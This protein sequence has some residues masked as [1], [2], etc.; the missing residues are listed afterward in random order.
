MLQKTGAIVLHTLKYGESKLVVDM[1]T[2]QHGR[3]TFM[4]PLS[5]SPRS[6]M[7]KQYF[8]PLTLLNIETDVRPQA[9]MQKL[10]DVSLLMPV[11]SLLSEPS[12]LAI[13]L[14]AS[15][16]LYHALRDEQ[17]NEPLF[18]Y[19]CNSIDWLDKRE[20]DYANFHL[21]FLMHLSRF[22]GFYP[23]LEEKSEMARIFDLREGTFRHDMPAHH[24]YLSPDETERIHLLMRM[25]YATM[26]L[27]K[28]NR[29]ARNRILD[30]LIRYY[31][32][33]LPAM[34]E[35]RSLEVFRELY[36]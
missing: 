16:F 29:I 15:E 10:H 33:H 27:F 4:V 13:A 35:M 36:G 6:K 9:Q 21:V 5:T 17:C 3:V 8:Q 7:K 1:F 14:F 32:L 28:L 23:N 30:V 20:Q 12:K 34:P 31:R 19:L 26:H 2:R 18:D 24:D 11:P 25:D 22:L